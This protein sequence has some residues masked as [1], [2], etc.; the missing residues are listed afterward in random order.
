MSDEVELAH[1]L[2]VL[3]R[4]LP[5]SPLW[6][7]SDFPNTMSDIWRRL[8]ILVPQFIMFIYLQNFRIHS[9]LSS[10]RWRKSCL[11]SCGD[12]EKLCIVRQNLRVAFGH[13]N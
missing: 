9:K 5:T 3:E 2:D 8:P 10:L 11:G 6:M 12:M 4:V 13:A 1:L 7:L